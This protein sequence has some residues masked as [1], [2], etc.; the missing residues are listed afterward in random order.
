MVTITRLLEEVKH[1]NSQGRRPM[2][3][4]HQHSASRICAGFMRGILKTSTCFTIIDVPVEGIL[5]LIVDMQAAGM[6]FPKNWEE[7]D[8]EEWFRELDRAIGRNNKRGD[9]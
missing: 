3:A 1:E 2:F 7:V 9:T 8:L 4:R 5:R 6:S